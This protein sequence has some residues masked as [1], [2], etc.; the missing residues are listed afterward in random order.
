MTAGGGTCPGGSGITQLAL[1]VEEDIIFSNDPAGAVSALGLSS[2]ASN[3][4][5]TT[6]IN[7]SVR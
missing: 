4:V 6:R 2:R 3:G 5:L 1:E 7:L